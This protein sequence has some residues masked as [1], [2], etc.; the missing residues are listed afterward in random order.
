MKK[1][2][3][4]GLACPKP[5]ILTKNALDDMEEGKVSTTVDN[6]IARE[7]LK[8]LANSLNMECKVE[9]ISDEEFV[10]TIEKKKTL[11]KEEEKEERY[12]L[13]FSSDKMGKGDDELGDILVK[14]FIY[15]VTE[16]KPLP[17]TILFY[18]GGVKLTVEG[19]PVLEDIKKLEKEGVEIISCGTCLDFFKL[20]EKLGVGTISNMYTIYENLSQADKTLVI[21]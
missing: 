3:A 17:N 12:T 16:T 11:N 4:K 18:N 2:D 5:V 14:S 13:A 10:V 19:S 20:K 7:N 21:G 15:T 6:E 8:K 9:D 1:I